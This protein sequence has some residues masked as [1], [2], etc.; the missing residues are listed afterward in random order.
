M[1]KILETKFD[2]DSEMKSVEIWKW[3]CP[4]YIRFILL[5]NWSK[6]EPAYTGW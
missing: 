6:L 4:Y 1:K 2:D 3:G 5:I